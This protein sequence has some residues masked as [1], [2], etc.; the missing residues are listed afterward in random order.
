MDGTP[1]VSG[2][3]CILVYLCTLCTEIFNSGNSIN[4]HI[5]GLDIIVDVLLTELC[6]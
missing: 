4:L 1:G 5:F 2:D 3:T 6:S